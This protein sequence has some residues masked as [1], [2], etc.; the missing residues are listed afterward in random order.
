M[1][2][3]W[4]GCFQNRIVRRPRNALG[5]RWQRPPPQRRHVLRNLVQCGDHREMPE[6][7]LRESDEPTRPTAGRRI[8]KDL[9]SR[10]HC[11]FVWLA[12]THENRHSMHS[13]RPS[14]DDEYRYRAG[15]LT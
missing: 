4:G 14:V 6:T 15:A 8:V 1:L 12:L 11:R 9:S 7:I 3:F 2:G 5:V 13:S 10:R